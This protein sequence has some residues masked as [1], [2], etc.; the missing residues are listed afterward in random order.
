MNNCYSHKYR[1]LNE[2]ELLI[3]LPFDNGKEKSVSTS[4][5]NNLEKEKE[6]AYHLKKCT[7]NI[8]QKY[9][10]TTVIT[11]Y[12]ILRINCILLSCNNKIKNLR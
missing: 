8:Y 2:A 11:F 4:F 6:S 1:N 10:I 3:R 9:Q 5:D 12:L 7:E